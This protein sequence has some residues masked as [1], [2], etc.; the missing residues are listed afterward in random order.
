MLLK[1]LN[2]NVTDPQT[3]ASAALAG[4]K[5]FKSRAIFFGEDLSW[6]MTKKRKLTLRVDRD[7]ILPDLIICPRRA[8]SVSLLACL[9]TP[10]TLVSHS[11]S[12]SSPNVV[13][14]T[15]IISQ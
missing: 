8:S 12:F 6:G 4:R 10:F 15:A 3:Q 14:S 1:V 7:K 11:R 9:Y 2:G 5:K 13:S